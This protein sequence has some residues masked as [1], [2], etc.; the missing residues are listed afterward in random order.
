MC[1]SSSK[2]S[3]AAVMSHKCDVTHK[4]RQ[5]YRPE[6]A[7]HCFVFVLLFFFYAFLFFFFFRLF[8]VQ[9]FA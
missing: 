6:V 4:P 5:R 8:F 3:A 9:N 1:S 7:K 2:I